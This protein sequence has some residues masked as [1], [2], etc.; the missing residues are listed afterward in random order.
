[1]T[2]PQPTSY[3][4][5]KTHKHSPKIGNK[6]GCLLSPFLFSIVLDI[7]VIAIRQKEEIKG[8]QIGKEEVKLSL[9]AD[10][11]ALCIENPKDS[12]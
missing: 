8:I 2:N 4:M 12:I 9:F 1:M 5:G 11:L 3:S 7:L 10:D 6:T